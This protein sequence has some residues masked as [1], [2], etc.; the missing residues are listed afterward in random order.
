M[1]SGVA[2]GAPAAGGRPSADAPSAGAPL[3]T[4][5]LGRAASASG[6]ARP[7]G[8]AL[9]GVPLLFRTAEVEAESTEESVLSP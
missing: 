9:A 4:A 8:R 3:A 1:A 7:S 2:P 6:R 5:L